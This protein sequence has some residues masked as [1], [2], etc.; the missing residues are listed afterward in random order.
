MSPDDKPVLDPGVQL[1][2][3]PDRRIEF[4]PLELGP[5]AR[6]RSGSVIYAGSIIGRKLETGHNVVI[7]EQNTLG[8]EVWIWSNS[9]VD[10][11]CRIGS[12]VRIHCGVYVCQG[13]ILEDE[14]FLAPGVVTA[15]DR[16]PVTT[17][18]VGPVLRTGARIGCNATIL[19]GVVVGRGALVGAGA[20]VTRDVPDGATVYGNPARGGKA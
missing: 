5:G 14:V 17:D 1:D 11:G 13:T 20:V 9:V 8:D 15:N 4:S 19:P 6:V 2:Y 12:R 3:P 18:F 10:Y 7:R 16:F